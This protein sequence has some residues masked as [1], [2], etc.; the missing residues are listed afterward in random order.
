[1]ETETIATYYTKRWPIEIFFRQSKNNLG[2]GTYQVRSAKAFIWLWILLT[3]TH[4]FVYESAQ[5]G[6]SFQAVCERFLKKSSLN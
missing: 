3:W 4:L 2:F 5:K 1:M 6:I